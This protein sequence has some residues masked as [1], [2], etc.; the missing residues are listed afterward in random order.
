MHVS[1]DISEAE[2]SV[3]MESMVI[4]AG[5][6]RGGKKK[7]LTCEVASKSCEQIVPQ[8]TALPRRLH[9]D[10]CQFGVIC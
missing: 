10:F 3:E 4:F 5:Y 9:V 6:F 7:L 1:Y 8:S 2:P